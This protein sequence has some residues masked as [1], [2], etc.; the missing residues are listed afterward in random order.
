[1]I[2]RELLATDDSWSRIR[3]VFLW[4]QLP[5]G[6]ACTMN[7]SIAMHILKALN[8][9]C[10]YEGSFMSILYIYFIQV[11]VIWEQITPSEIMPP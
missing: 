6:C 3:F 1:M 4:M 8:E 11:G 10:R 2:A 7:G 9:V 5:I